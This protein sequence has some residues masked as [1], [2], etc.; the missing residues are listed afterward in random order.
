MAQLRVSAWAI[1][2]PLPIALLMLGL[3]L[4]GAL[5]YGRLPIKQYPDISFPAVTVS[6]TQSGAAPA[7]L[8]TQVTRPVENAL[9]GLSDVEAIVSTVAQGNSA[10]TIQFHLGEDLQKA[11]DQVRSRIDQLRPQLPAGIDAPVVQRVEIADAPILSYAVA[12]DDMSLSDL[13]WFIQDTI[14][15]RLQQEDGVAG[16]SRVG[17]VD[18]E[19]NVIVDP[20]RLTASGLTM[21]QLNDALRRFNV[22]DPGG[23]ALIGGQEQSVRVL[24]TASTVAGLRNLTLPVAGGRFVKLSDIAAIGDGQSEA[25]AFARL[26]GQPVVGFQ[27]SKTKEASELA[28]EDRVQAAVAELMAAHPDIHISKIFSTVDETRASYNATLEALVEGLA[29][30]GLAVLLFLRDGRATLITAMAMPA[31]LIPTFAC[32]AALGFSLNLVTLLALTLVTGILVDDAI[33]EIENIEK[34]LQAGLSPYDAAMTGADS[35]GLAVVA[36]TAAIIVVFTPVSFM[37]GIPGQFF[38]EFGFTVSIA[39]LFSLLVARLLTPLLAAYLLKP[40][41]H[42]HFADSTPTCWPGSCRIECWRC[43]QASRF[44]QGLWRSPRSCLSGSSPPAMP[45]IST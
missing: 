15:R 22:D 7:E 24:N 30:A 34:R 20:A 19:I 33:V 29:L 23:R 2:N 43:S 41:R 40:P 37:A 35:I 8:E 45:T 27:V 38:R 36:T 6:I 3:I 4:A 16:V 9:A 31:S 5:S 11:T 10:T 28:V 21:P 18:R 44:L 14:T 12:S 17:G 26:N 32:M 39:V 1:R 13:S 42:P 25:R